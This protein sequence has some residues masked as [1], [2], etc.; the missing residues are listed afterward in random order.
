MTVVPSPPPDKPEPKLKAVKAARP[1][2]KRRP[3]AK[4][5]V[6]K[7]RPTGPVAKVRRALPSSWEPKIHRVAQVP[8]LRKA[9]RRLT[10]LSKS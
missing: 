9:Y 6:R 1:A 7:V 10:G 8:A 2:P 5:P 3:K 4:K